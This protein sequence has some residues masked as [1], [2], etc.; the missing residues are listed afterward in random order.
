MEDKTGR[1]RGTYGDNRD[2]F[3]LCSGFWQEKLK[4]RG[5]LEKAKP[6]CEA[7]IKIS[8]KEVEWKAMEWIHLSQDRNKWR[9]AVNMVI[10][11]RI[12]K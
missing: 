3:G 7:N 8:V 2:V 9:A 10:K 1:A 6:R 4:E 11:L 5:R 12:V